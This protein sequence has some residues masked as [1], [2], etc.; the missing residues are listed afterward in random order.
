MIKGGVSLTPVAVRAGRILSERLF[1]NRPNL[2]ME[3]QN[4]ATVIFSH[5]PIGTVGLS[6]DKAIETFSE[7]KVRVYTSEFVNMHYGLVPADGSVHRSKSL[8]KLVTHIESDGTERM[9][10]VHGIG[11]GIDEMMQLASVALNMNATK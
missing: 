7:E 2:K 6:A 9:V 11:R 5:P 1:N 4:V 8:F 10:G 3:Y